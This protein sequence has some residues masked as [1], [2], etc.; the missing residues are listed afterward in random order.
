MNKPQKAK[1]FSLRCFLM[2]FVR[3]TGWFPG[4]IWLRPKI[5]FISREARKKIRGGT[6]LIANH[7]SFFDP[8][9]TMY[10][11]WY[12]RQYFVCHH[13]LMESRAAPLFRAAG[14]MIPIHADN[15][16]IDSFRTI[17][18]TLKE[19][20]MVT[21]FPEGHIYRDEMSQFKSG[22][23]LMSIQ[24]RCPI[25][26]MYIKPRKH[27]YSRLK[28]VIGEPVDIVAASGGRPSFAKIQA[29]TKELQEKETI[30]EEYAKKL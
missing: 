11:V 14:C 6:L 15:V 2:D 19:G 18:D 22:M 4:F 25:V 28:A 9:H 26:P 30:L 29:I 17:T 1:L 5:R 10:S 8:L 20:K 13:T 7:T 21:I 3:I 23:I 27:W 24:S 12:R 16:S